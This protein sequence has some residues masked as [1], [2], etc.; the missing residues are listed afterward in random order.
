MASRS[1]GVQKPSEKYAPLAR[2]GVGTNNKP[3]NGPAPNGPVRRGFVLNKA[4]ENK[5]TVRQRMDQAAGKGI[6]VVKKGQVTAGAELD[7]LREEIDGLES[8]LQDKQAELDQLA[9]AQTNMILSKE[10]YQ[11]QEEDIQDKIKK[12]DKKNKESQELTVARRTENTQLKQ[13]EKQLQDKL[14]DLS[15]LAK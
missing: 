10:N 13:K 1:P 12:Y 4:A 6:S 9:A 14:A 7:K 8:G 5:P 3:G 11:K 2:Y 15:R